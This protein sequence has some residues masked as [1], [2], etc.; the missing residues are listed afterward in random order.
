M[1]RFWSPTAPRRKLHGGNCGDPSSTGIWFLV[2]G[3]RREILPGP[4]EPAK[5]AP[6]P[7]RSRQ[8][9]DGGRQ[10]ETADEKEEAPVPPSGC[11][12]G[13]A[14]KRAG[15]RR[16]PCYNW[17]GNRAILEPKPERCAISTRSRPTRPGARSVAFKRQ[18]TSDSSPRTNR[19]CGHTV[20]LR[21]ARLPSGSIWTG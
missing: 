14:R 20:E 16:R 13:N 2:Q 17:P 10:T 4:P 11:G 21:F 6:A 15:V 19:S 7:E 12:V 9:G 3:E 8:S 5:L 18:D 1:L